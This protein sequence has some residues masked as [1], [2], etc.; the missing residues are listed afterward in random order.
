MAG[1]VRFCRLSCVDGLRVREEERVK[2]PSVLAE[3]GGRRGGGPAVNRCRDFLGL[4]LGL[5]G[6]VWT[7]ATKSHQH[8]LGSCQK[9]FPLALN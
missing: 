8:H 2:Y 1:T 3:W 4:I 9:G 7:A 5:L 6:H